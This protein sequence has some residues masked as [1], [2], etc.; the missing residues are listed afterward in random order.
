MCLYTQLVAL[1]CVPHT[2]RRKRTHFCTAVLGAASIRLRFH[3]CQTR[4]IGG[5]AFCPSDD[6]FVWCHMLPV[7]CYASSCFLEG[8]E[9]SSAKKDNYP[10]TCTEGLKTTK[11]PTSLVFDF[12]QANRSKPRREGTSCAPRKTFF[13]IIFA[14]LVLRAIFCP[15]KHYYWRSNG[16]SPWYRVSHPDCWWCEA[17]TCLKYAYRANTTS[18]AEK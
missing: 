14:F 13:R 1:F 6:R 3:C 17:V 9:R 16:W 4:T 7:L 10:A 5:K 2:H 15:Q 12:S 8:K 11:L 18:H